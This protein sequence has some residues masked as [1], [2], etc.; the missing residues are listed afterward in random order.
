VSEVL[1]FYGV[2]HLCFTVSSFLELAEYIF[3]IPGVEAFLSEH[4][5]QDTLEQLFGC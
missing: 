3:K 4:L 2:I 5:S 1:K